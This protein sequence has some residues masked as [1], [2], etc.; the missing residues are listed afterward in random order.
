MRVYRLE[1]VVGGAHLM[2]VDGRA[3]TESDGQ[4]VQLTPVEKAALNL[5]NSYTVYQRAY[6]NRLWH[7]KATT[8]EVDANRPQK[9]WRLLPMQYLP[10]DIKGALQN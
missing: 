10:T 2:Y 7:R 8:R 5:S 6:S 9:A 4:Q 3:G 1:K